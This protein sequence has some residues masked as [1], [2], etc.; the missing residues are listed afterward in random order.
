MIDPGLMSPVRPPRPIS[1][2]HPIARPGH[3]VRPGFPISIMP[4]PGPGPIPPPV[5]TSP[6]LE[7][8]VSVGLHLKA[9]DIKVS[10]ENQVARTFIKQVFSNDT[11]R[12]LAGTYLFPLPADTTFS[13]FSLHI[14]GKPIEGKILAAEEARQQYEEIVRRMVDPGLLE[15]ADYKTVRARIFPIPPHGTKTVELEY[16]QLLKAEDGLVKYKYPLK[17]EGEGS[18]SDEIKVDLS[19]KD[20][21][22]V[23]SIWSPS[24]NV[25]VTR[26][27][28]NIAKVALL[29]KDSLPDKDF[30][31]YYGI[32]DK[33][34]SANLLTHK[35]PSEDG[36][37]LLTL[38]PPQ[39]PHQVG[40]KDIVLVADTSGSMAGDKIDETKRALK[41]VIN[42]LSAEDR[43]GLIQFNTDVE[44]FKLHLLPATQDNKKSASQYVDG[45]EA[46][47]GTNISEALQLS[48]SMLAENAG[49]PSYLVLMTDGQPTVGETDAA[50]IIKSISADSK[51]RVFDFGVGY[52]VN[53]LFLNKLSEEH[54]GTSQYVEP[55][56]NLETAVSSFYD[57]IKNPVLTDVNIDI[58]GV[59]TK[60]VY[61]REVKDIFAGTQVMLLGKY[62]DGGKSV[63]H[64]TGTINGVKKA[65]SFNLNFQPEEGENSYL[66]RLWAMRRIGHL[67]DVAKEN[68]NSKEV[69][70]EIVALS[71]KY[72]IISEFTSFLVTDPNESQQQLGHLARGG[73]ARPWAA[74]AGGA[75]EVA[76]KSR[77]HFMLS[78]ATNGSIAPQMA[79]LPP[80]PLPFASPGVAGNAMGSP[81]HNSRRG[82]RYNFAPSVYQVQSASSGANDVISAKKSNA[83][84]DATTVADLDTR[85]SANWKSVA[86][87]SFTF[88]DNFWTESGLTSADLKSA[89]EITF[90]SDEYFAL[91]HKNPQ[92]A[93]YLSVGQQVIVKYNGVVYKILA[94]KQS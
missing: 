42:S 80:P 37:F 53:T 69:V 83:L 4:F 52:D 51:V 78:G 6:L 13:S 17:A 84:K 93:K 46:R 54:H 26:D 82:S 48:K 45:L 63:L 30:I 68:G 73:F 85:A 41:Y 34:M 44:A 71:Q 55:N 89:K 16:T 15:Y 59:K 43:F 79:A 60:D 40:A 64:L 91:I 92:L 25:S 57:K 31:L 70:D 39:Q 38:S 5:T 77:A 11:D 94:A 19:I 32:S 21:Q 62:S 20:K 9:Q 18:P 12:N 8:R 23:R 75:T 49:H 67:T 65:Y 14:D 10:I 61:P 66:P 56:E 33:A 35:M 3:P 50:K 88:K 7:G 76:Q 81:G 2:H 72:G 58:D 24:H 47:G 1:V 27:G 36:Y 87:K 74:G 22:G 28:S 86:D 29:E 90:L